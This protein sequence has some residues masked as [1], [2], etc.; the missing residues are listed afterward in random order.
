VPRLGVEASLLELGRRAEAPVCS[1]GGQQALAIGPVASQVGALVNDGFIP[2]EP[3]PTESVE[4]GFGRG[5][6]ASSAIG[7]LDPEEKVAPE[8]P[9][10]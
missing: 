7:V 6:G 2:A 10:I 3:E 8:M 5:V 9:G 1:S 4:D